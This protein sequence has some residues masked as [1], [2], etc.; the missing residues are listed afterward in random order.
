MALLFGEGEGERREREGRERKAERETGGYEP[1]ALHAAIHL[2]ILGGVK[3]VGEG[4]AIVIAVG[5]SIY[6]VP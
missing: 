4:K 5:T 1:L 2:A 3:S 6:A